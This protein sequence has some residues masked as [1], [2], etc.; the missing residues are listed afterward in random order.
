MEMF[1][2]VVFQMLIWCDV[3]FGLLCLPA[4]VAGSD[5][6]HCFVPAPNDEDTDPCPPWFIQQEIAGDNTT[7]ECV[8]GPPTDGIVCNPKTCNTSLL[9]QYC[10]TY[11][12]ITK[13]QAVGICFFESKSDFMTTLPSNVSELNNFM[14]GYF[15]REGQLCGAC[16]KGYGPA[17]LTYDLQCAKCSSQNYGW[18]L[19]LLIGFLPITVFYLVIVMFQVSATSGPLNAFIFSAQVITSVIENNKSAFTTNAYQFWSVQYIEKI[20]ITF[21][22][23]W[24]L[25]FFRSTIPPFCVSENITTLHAVAL[26]Y[27]PAL[28]PLLLI[29]VTYV[30]IELHDRNVRVVVWMWKPFHRCLALFQKHSRWDPKASI[31]STFITFLTLAYTKLIIVSGKLL[32]EVSVTDIQGN[33]SRFALLDSTVPYFGKE[34]LPFAILAVAVLSTFIALPPLLLI[35]YPTKTFQKLLGCLKIRWPA[36]HIFADVFQGCYKN[37]TDGPKDYRCFAAFYFIARIVGFVI[38]VACVEI[39][40]LELVMSTVLF[41]ICS[42]LFALLRPYKKNWLNVLDSLI[43]ASLGVASLWMI[44]ATKPQW[45]QLTGFIATLPL[46][47]FLTYVAYRLLL[48]LRILQKCQQK[49]RNVCQYLQQRW[50]G[51]CFMQQGLYNEEQLP[52]GLVNPCEYQPLP[53][54]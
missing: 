2:L 24:N 34:H 16:K 50:Q 32:G 29:V 27:L 23:I 51:H 9:F 22:G 15:N 5:Q 44:Y 35:L 43:L 37:R 4:V 41:I 11:N 45:I 52:D 48:W 26:Q 25:D 8:C 38:A 19:Y 1:R 7:V 21:Y 28:Y 54:N 17:L 18:A 42:L 31:I 30:L 10:I 39:N 53:Q 20:F 14:C 49:S 40:S 46:I 36:L 6:G 47:Y 12:P 33:V 13:T 3:L